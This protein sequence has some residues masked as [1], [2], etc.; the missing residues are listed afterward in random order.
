MMRVAFRTVS[1]LGMALQAHFVRSRSELERRMIS[2][3]AGLVRIVAMAALRLPFPKTLGP[4]E[5]LDDERGLAKP[6][7]LIERFPQK[8]LI[9][10]LEVTWKELAGRVI[11]ALPDGRLHMAP[12]ANSNR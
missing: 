8:L 7:V 3:L 4:Y 9:R 2:F 10:A 1:E 11:G 6:P 12:G 5:R